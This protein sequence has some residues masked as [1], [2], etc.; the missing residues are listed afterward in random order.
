M[1]GGRL[2][3]MIGIR[4]HLRALCEIDAGSAGVQ[5]AEGVLSGNSAEPVWVRNGYSEAGGDRRPS[6]CSRFAGAPVAQTSARLRTSSHSSTSVT[7][8]NW[9]MISAI[10]WQE[11]WCLRFLPKPRTFRVAR[12][13]VSSSFDGGIL[14]AAI[15]CCS[16]FSAL[17]VSMVHGIFS[18]GTL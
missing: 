18:S 1:A 2:S 15:L 6:A 5:P 4:A 3:S 8:S 7:R 16:S 17:A 12:R 10:R 9:P 11:V 13:M 14:V